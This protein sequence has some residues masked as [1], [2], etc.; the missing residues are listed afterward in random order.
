M[1]SQQYSNKHLREV[2]CSFHFQE[3]QPAWDVTYFGRLYDLLS[4]EG[5]TRKEE[6]KSVQ[7]T[8]SANELRAVQGSAE[9]TELVCRAE[10]GHRIVLFSKQSISVHFINGQHYPGWPV[11]SAKVLAP[12][13]EAFR[14]L[15]L[16][17]GSF[18]VA[19]SYLSK[20][21]VSAKDQVEDFLKFVT[22][23]DGAFGELQSLSVQRLMTAEHGQFLAK[24]NMNGNEVFFETGSIVQGAEGDLSKWNV[25]AEQAHEPLGAFFDSL[26]TD[27]LKAVL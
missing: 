26:I 14:R 1:P 18:Q 7:I 20:L 15:G 22:K 13:V 16:G 6:R 27:R 25:L 10:D 17:T 5:Y 11:F 3:E 9:Q 12:V 4:K 21:P 24:L 19:L 23:M 8:L 2:W